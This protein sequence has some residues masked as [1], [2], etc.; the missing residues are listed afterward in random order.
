MTANTAMLERDLLEFLRAN[1]ARMWQQ[2]HKLLVDY[3]TPGR[4]VVPAR[5]A[6][7]VT[8]DARFFGL[9]LVCADVIRPQ[10]LH[11]APEGSSPRRQRMLA[12]DGWR[13]MVRS[14]A[15]PVID[16]ELMPEELMLETTHKDELSRDMEIHA[17]QK[18]GRRVEVVDLPPFQPQRR[19]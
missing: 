5:Y 17:A 11:V 19:A 14:Y 10:V 4:V 3:I 13:W 6:P 9:P 18:C 12:R 7:V 2:K 16:G 8:A 15:Q 1:Q